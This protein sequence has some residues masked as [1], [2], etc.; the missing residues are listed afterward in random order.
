MRRNALSLPSFAHPLSIMITPHVQLGGLCFRHRRG[1][2]MAGRY[3]YAPCSKR[4]AYLAYQRDLL[5]YLGGNGSRGC[6]IWEV[7]LLHRYDGKIFV[8]LLYYYIISR[9]SEEL[10][11]RWKSISLRFP[12]PLDRPS[13]GNPC[14]LIANFPFRKEGIHGQCVK[15]ATHQQTEADKKGEKSRRRKVKKERKK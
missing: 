13:L 11:F 3:C 8:K 5:S 14:P 9:R 4:A 2:T 6:H 15:H 7:T 10:I 1:V 12:S